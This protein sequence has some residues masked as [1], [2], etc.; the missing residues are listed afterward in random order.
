MYETLSYMLFIGHKHVL[1]LLKTTEL[2][3]CRVK[4]RSLGLD[5]W[6]A[7]VMGGKL[8]LQEVYGC[9]MCS[10]PHSTVDK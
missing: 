3:L 6:E 8:L 7:Y 2:F 1:I 9:I 4:N 5:L 10:F